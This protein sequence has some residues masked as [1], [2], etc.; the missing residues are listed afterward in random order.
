MHHHGSSGLRVL[1][2]DDEAD[3]ADTL[4]IYLELAG[5]QFKSC[6]TAAEAI[7]A[8]D[9]FSPDACILDINLPDLDGYALARRIRN[10]A[11][12]RAIPIVAVTGVSGPELQQQ[13]AFSGFDLHMTKPVDPEKLAM[14][15]ADIIILRGDSSDDFGID[16]RDL[17]IEIQC[18]QR[19]QQI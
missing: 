2:V 8:L 1:C 3:I 10:W 14:I 15:L 18:N 7:R 9:E 12:G 5:F 17:R 19:Q 6:Y 11:G 16:S 4:G 13:L